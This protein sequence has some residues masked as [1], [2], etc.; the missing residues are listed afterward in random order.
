MSQRDGAVVPVSRGR[1]ALRLA[2]Y[3][4]LTLPLMPVQAL[5]LAMRSPAATR[6]PH[7]YHRRCCAILGLDLRRH[8]APSPDA[9]TL[10]VANHISYFDIVALSA[11]APVSFVAKREVASW[12]FFGWLARLQRTVFVG[13]DRRRVDGERDSLAAAL[14]EGRSLVLFAEGTSYDGVHLRPFKSSLLAAAE[15]ATDGRPL[16]VQPVTIAYTRLDGMPIGRHLRPFYAWF[17]DMELPGHLWQALGIGRVTVEIEFHA[18]VTFARFGSRKALTR[19]CE[20][21]V[22]RTLFQLNAGRRHAA[23]SGPS[24]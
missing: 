15:I 19:F 5:L 7:W 6:L 4:A 20:E 3:A 11:L 2:L 24:S 13:R 17:G 16:T 22:G 21:T 8:G 23:A 14:A 12:P 10:F 9:P 18:P 1:A